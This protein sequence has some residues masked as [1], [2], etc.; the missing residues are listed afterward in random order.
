MSKKILLSGY[1]GFDNVGDE[2]VLFSIVR[3]LRAVMGDEAEI[4]VLSNNPETTS[5][6]Y[7]VRA[8]DRW[9]KK[10]LLTEIKAC[11]LFIS[12]GGS[13]LQDVTSGVDLCTGYRPAQILA[14]PPADR[15]TFK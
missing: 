8:V 14:Q 13:L 2:A 6:R 3:D 1:Y 10:T 4:T 11:D 9:N 7:D 15:Q 12:G 5:A